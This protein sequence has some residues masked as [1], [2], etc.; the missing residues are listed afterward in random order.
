MK[1]ANLLNIILA[2]GIVA[3]S[4]TSIMKTENNHNMQSNDN[5]SSRGAIENI[6]TRTSIRQFTDE[7]VTEAQVDTLLRAAM[8]A[9]TAMNKRPWDFIVITDETL[10]STIS[11]KFP[12]ASMSKQ[13]AVLIIA[14]GN[15][16]K[17]IEGEGEPY[18]IQDV[19]AATENILLAAHAMGLGAVWCGIHPIAQR[20]KDLVALL[21]IPSALK[22]LNIIAIGHPAQNPAPK[23]K[24][25]ESAIHYNAFK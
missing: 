21:N 25:D 22:P 4:I 8:A 13:A 23:D 6:M 14:C 9:P 1:A 16:D 15:M 18:W 20:E 2:L 12:N 17:A 11:E 7:K 5:S 24:W 19:S 3:V 10:K